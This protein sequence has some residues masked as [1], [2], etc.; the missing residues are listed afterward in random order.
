MFEAAAHVS[1]QA[2]GSFGAA[3]RGGVHRC[4]YGGFAGITVTPGDNARILDYPED[5]VWD[6]PQDSSFTF[7]K[8]DSLE[9]IIDALNDRFDVNTDS[10]NDPY[11]GH[12]YV[13]FEGRF[14]RWDDATGTINGQTWSSAVD[15]KYGPND[16]IYGVGA[17]VPTGRKL[18][19][20]FKKTLF[21]DPVA[22]NKLQNGYIMGFNIGVVDDDRQ[23]PGANKNG[24]RTQDLEI[25]YFWANRERH[26]G[27]TPAA[28]AELTPEQQQ[29]EECLT[30]LFPLI[31]HS[32]GRLT[33]DGAGQVVFTAAPSGDPD[34][35]R[36][37]WG[38][39][40]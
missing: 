26:Q 28:W 36:M 9:I 38:G 2:R 14:S 4:E 19:A 27:M 7:W 34:P 25:Q 22:G 30:Q 37:G 29:D 18:E 10:S 8:D 3:A 24:S 21:E 33:H 20:R 12:C 23:G 16:E 40:S 5:R 11:G 17:E 13:N 15:W 6:G 35:A 31:I 39:R 1:P 32:T